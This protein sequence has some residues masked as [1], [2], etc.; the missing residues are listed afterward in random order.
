MGLIQEKVKV[1]ITKYNIEHYLNKG[2]SNATDGYYIE[3]NTNDL[4]KGSGIKVDVECDYC[5]KIFKKSYRDYLR[6]KDDICCLDC[7][8]YKF[9]KTNLERYGT[10]CSLRNPEI[11]EKAKTTLMEKYGVEYPL[12]SKEIQDK[13]IKTFQERYNSNSYRLTPKDISNITKKQHKKGTTSSKEQD[14]L[15]NIYNGILNPRLG[16]YYV[17]IMFFDD[18][19]CCEYNGGGH[20]LAAI[21]GTTTVEEIKAK[22]YKKYAFCFENGFKTFVIENQKSGLPNKEI[23]LKIKERAF[24]ILKNNEDICVVMY[25]IQENSEKLLKFNDL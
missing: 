6:T 15:N 3:V 13:C 19:I 4:S 20:Y 12:L 14:E 9:A 17:D 11:H 7:R 25:N 8:K 21:H 2:Y 10:A 1:K 23:L 22:D 5:H 18:K 24:Q 16:K